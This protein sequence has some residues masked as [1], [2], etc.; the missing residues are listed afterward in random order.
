MPTIVH[1]LAL[2]FT[3]VISHPVLAKHTAGMKLSAQGADLFLFAPHPSERIL[4]QKTYV[5]SHGDSAPLS[6]TQPGAGESVEQS[7]CCRQ[8]ELGTGHLSLPPG[9]RRHTEQCRFGPRHP[10]WKG[11]QGV[12]S[13]SEDEEHVMGGLGE[14]SLEPFLYLLPLLSESSALR[15]SSSGRG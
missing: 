15:P 10:I 13:G 14:M 3:P 5:P 2:L 11:R 6:C 9:R 4:T 12:G 8:A 1:S 7:P